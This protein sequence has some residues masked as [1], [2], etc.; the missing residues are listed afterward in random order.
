MFACKLLCSLQAVTEMTK[1]D[2]ELVDKANMSINC[3]LW[4]DEATAF[5]DNG[6]VPGAII[7]IKAAKV[8]DY[9]G[10]LANM[11]SVTFSSLL[12]LPSCCPCHPCQPF[13]LVYLVILVSWR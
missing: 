1:R 8:S 4:G 5:G 6:G 9:G 3:T 7:A 13:V 2:I 12:S 10:E 11:I